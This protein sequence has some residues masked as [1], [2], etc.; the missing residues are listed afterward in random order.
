LVKKGGRSW[1]A[2]QQPSRPK[3]KKQRKRKRVDASKAGLSQ[4]IRGKERVAIFS[5]A[6]YFFLE[7]ALS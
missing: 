6:S 2:S 3:T 1:G 5:A 4:G 7:S